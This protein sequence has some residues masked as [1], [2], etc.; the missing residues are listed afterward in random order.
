MLHALL[1]GLAL[2]ATGPRLE[3]SLTVGAGWDSNLNHAGADATRVDAGFGF[4]GAGAGASLDVGK[5][6][7]LFAGLRLDVERYLETGG[8]SSLSDLG[9]T[10]AAVETALVRDLGAR[11]ALVLAPSAFRTWTGDPSRDTTGFA[12]RITLRVK[13]LARVA[14]RAFYAHVERRAEDPVFSSYPDR[15]GGSAEWNPRG[16]TYLSLGWAAEWGEEV[17]YRE[18][19]S[20]GLPGMGGRMVGTFGGTEAY[21]AATL[22]QSVSAAVETGLGRKA[23]LFAR[24]DWR[25]V[26][27]DEPGFEGHAVTAGLG[28]RP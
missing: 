26:T 3:T 14:L 27:S 11:V 24:W 9:S 1:A 28:L 15:V 10:A 8:R 12:G 25:K 5:S 20:G 16:R 17:F 18:V 21:R 19:A 4:V 23:H 13:P 2:A 6:T 7:S 22:G